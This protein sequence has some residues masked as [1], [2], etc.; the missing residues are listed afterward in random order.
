ME[1]THS[2]T[3]ACYDIVFIFAAKI[4]IAPAPGHSAQL[5]KPKIAAEKSSNRIFKIILIII[6]IELQFCPSALLLSILPVLGG[7]ICCYF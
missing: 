3:P 1:G 2:E 5:G 6:I 7:L 4:F